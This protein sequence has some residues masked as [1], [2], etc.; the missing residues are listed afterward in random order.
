MHDINLRSIQVLILGT[1]SEFSDWDVVDRM[2]IRN[3]A[4]TL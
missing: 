2:S 1:D 4:N 3:K